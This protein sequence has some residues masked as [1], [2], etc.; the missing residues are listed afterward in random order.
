MATDLILKVVAGGD[1]GYISSTGSF[2]NSGNYFPIGNY[3]GSAFK[4]FMRFLNV[5]IPKDATINSAILGVRAYASDS[6]LPVYSRFYCN[7]VDDVTAAPVSAVE[8]N[9][10]T[11]TTAYIDWSLPAFTMYTWYNS[12]D[13]KTVIQ[14]IISR[15]GW[16]SGNDL[17]V[18]WKDNGS[19]SY[20]MKQIYTYEIGASSQLTLTI[21][22]T[23]P[24]YSGKIYGITPAKVF[25]TL[26]KK[27]YGV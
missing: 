18:I 24:G 10:L 17:M 12:P 27:I 14:E 1:D 2:D 5:T 16:V 13:I 3:A 15:A 19:A 26:P 23:D 9:A 6:N 21:N 25:G 22:Y 11:L 8:Y 20:Y 4:A 7:D